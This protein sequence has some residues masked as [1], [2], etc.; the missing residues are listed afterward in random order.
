[1]SAPRGRKGKKAIVIPASVSV[2]TKAP[3]VPATIMDEAR[4]HLLKTAAAVSARFAKRIEDPDYKPSPAD[5]SAIFAA[6]KAMEEHG[7]GI[8][9]TYARLTDLRAHVESLTRDLK[10]SEDRLLAMLT[11]PIDPPK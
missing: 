2:A 3:A 5:L 9:A 11:K 6:L 7:A 8:A 1:M 10:T 4:A